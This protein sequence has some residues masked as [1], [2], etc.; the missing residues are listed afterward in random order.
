MITDELLEEL[1]KENKGYIFRRDEE[2]EVSYVGEVE[3]W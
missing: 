1:N 2:Y 3:Q